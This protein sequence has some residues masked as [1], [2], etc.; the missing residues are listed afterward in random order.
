MK[1]IAQHADTPLAF[2]TAAGAD[3]ITITLKRYKRGGVITVIKGHSITLTHR[4][5]TKTRFN[6]IAN[7][8]SQG[9]AYVR[10]W[11]KLA[12]R[13][14][15]TPLDASQTQLLT[16]LH[17]LHHREPVTGT[18]YTAYTDKMIDL[19]DVCLALE[20]PAILAD[21]AIKTI[22]HMFVEWPELKLQSQD[23]ENIV[24][25]VTDDKIMD[26]FDEHEDGD[27]L[28]QRLFDLIDVQPDDLADGPTSIEI[29]DTYNQTEAQADAEWEAKFEAEF[30]KH[31]RTQGFPT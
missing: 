22:G 4:V 21:A 31:Q 20:E 2:T 10:R 8:L 27:E 25:I 12:P 17:K 5:P 19:R 26:A 1:L 14:A 29:D 7:Y 28:V 30:E 15:M 11:A 6:A 18:P 24:R 9:D 23:L 16:I 13:K 3:R